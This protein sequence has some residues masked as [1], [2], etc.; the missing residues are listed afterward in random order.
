MHT[1]T[2]TRVTSKTGSRWEKT[3]GHV[4]HLGW[5]YQAGW[6]LQSPCRFYGVLLGSTVF[7]KPGR[8][9]VNDSKPSIIRCFCCFIIDFIVKFITG[10]V[11]KYS[12][13]EHCKDLKGAFSVF[14]V[15]KSKNRKNICPEFTVYFITWWQRWHLKLLS[16]EW[17]L[18]CR[19]NNDR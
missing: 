14:D 12:T 15:S 9:T 3:S 6:S 11:P 8:N 18:R 4:L 19:V 2:N 13:I 17:L 5:A 7:W 1:Q 10:S 16:V